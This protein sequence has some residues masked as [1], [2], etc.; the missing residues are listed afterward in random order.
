[1][2]LGELLANRKE[3]ATRWFNLFPRV[4]GSSERH[5]VRRWVSTSGKY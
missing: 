5:T 4:G 1:M 2:F 3:L